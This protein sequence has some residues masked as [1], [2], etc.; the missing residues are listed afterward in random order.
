[1]MRLDSNERSQ[2]PLD[3]VGDIVN[4]LHTFKDFIA[5]AGVSKPWRS[6][7]LSISTRPQL[8]WL[9][10]SE[11]PSTD[12]RGFFSLCDS[13]RYQ[14]R[15]SEVCGKRCWG[16]PHGWVVTLGPDYETHLVHLMKRVRISLPPLNTIRRQAAREEW[17]RLV[18]KFIL[19]KEPS[20]ELLFLV[21]AIFGPMNLLAFARV[22]GGGATLNRRGRGEWAFVTNPN[23]MKFKDVACFNGQMYG[24]CEKGMLVRFELDSPVSAEVQVISP[25][26]EGVCEP[27]KLYLVESLDNLFG[28]F[29]YGFYISSERRHETVSFL[30]YKFNFS[31]SAWEEVTDLKDHA[32]FVGD[33]NSW[34]FPTSTIPSKSNSIYFTDDHWDWQLYPGV[35]YGGYDVGVFDMASRVMQPLPFGKDK[36][37]FYS[38]PTWV[39]PTVRLN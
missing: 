36:P 38:R 7:C 12:K 21:I 29:R 19:F 22:G 37:R 32:V 24:L 10:L 5:A 26:P 28:V 33:G 16:S 34:C 30:V 13:N 27:Q 20:N 3:V 2:L 15:L 23:N 35:A 9:M 17:F 8:P 25:H 18:N 39:T 31:A 14:L 11:T 1:M 4:R 6:A